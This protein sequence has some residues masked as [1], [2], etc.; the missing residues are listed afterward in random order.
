M[1][2]KII[3][4]LIKIDVERVQFGQFDVKAIRKLVCG[5]LFLN[6]SLN[7]IMELEIIE[8]WHHDASEEQ[9]CARRQKLHIGQLITLELKPYGYF[10]KT[11]G[12]A[13]WWVG[14]WK[15]IVSLGLR[16]QYY[17]RWFHGCVKF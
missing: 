11:W 6:A 1:E 12:L 16:V 8:S 10:L 5:K 2:T 3:C 9:Q 7:L 4:N 15:T 13:Y 14:K 17:T